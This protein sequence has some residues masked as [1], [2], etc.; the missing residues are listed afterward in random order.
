MS[1]WPFQHDLVKEQIIAPV[2]ADTDSKS[3]FSY[4]KFQ[5][6]LSLF[7]NLFTIFS[8]LF[9]LSLSWSI[10]TFVSAPVPVYRETAAID[11]RQ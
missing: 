2:L 7:K 9:Y 4:L 8:L 11:S 10:E 5:E 6:T 3:A 1:T